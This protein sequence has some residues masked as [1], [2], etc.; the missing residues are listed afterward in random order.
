MKYIRQFISFKE[1]RVNEEFLGLGKF[2]KRMYQRAQENIR[3]TEGGEEVEKIFNK[4]LSIIQDEINKQTG[5]K[6]NIEKKTNESII[7]EADE[8]EET[9]EEET[10]EGSEK[11]NKPDK[12][13]DIKKLKEKN[14]IITQII[15]KVKNM[16]L[17]EMTNVLANKGGAEKNPKLKMIIDLK[18][19]QFELDVLK[20]KIKALDES[21]NP[22]SKKT[23]ETLKK[24]LEN[25]TKKQQ[26][27][28]NKLEKVGKSDDKPKDEVEKPEFNYE[29]GE[30]ITYKK[31]DGDENT[32][33]F[34]SKDGNVVTIKTENKPEGFKVNIDK[35][36]KKDTQDK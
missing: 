22:E 15:D 19:D 2:L 5:I 21:E 35:V 34:V 27:G 31:K 16:A 10:E 3:N 30:D 25:Q 13:L 18:K 12:G 24:D 4:Y 14:A 23:S 8:V 33:K 36:V 9:T 11:S 1:N 29:E 17:K 32:G 6:L 20:A 7:L 26:E 28:W